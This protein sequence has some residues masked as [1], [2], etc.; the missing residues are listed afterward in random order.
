MSA[1]RWERHDPADSRR[2]RFTQ[3]LS[4]CAKDIKTIHPQGNR[5]MSKRFN[6]ENNMITYE[7]LPGST[8]QSHSLTL[9]ILF[10]GKMFTNPKE[11]SVL[12]LITLSSHYHLVEGVS[13]CS[14]H[15]DLPGNS[16][17]RLNSIPQ[18]LGMLPGHNLQ[19][20]ALFRNSLG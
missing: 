5:K 15:C 11:S 13:K 14:K 18:F 19:L 9:W 16:A 4:C 1:V 2:G 12:C 7:D 6:W 10:R 8:S 20:S 17:S 3:S